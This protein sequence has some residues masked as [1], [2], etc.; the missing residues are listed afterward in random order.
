[1]ELR[2]AKRSLV[3]QGAS[4][5]PKFPWMEN[6]GL[7]GEEPAPCEAKP[8]STRRERVYQ[9]GMTAY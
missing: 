9:Y 4:V 3:L 5:Y 7:L 2:R 8:C 6:F 1:M